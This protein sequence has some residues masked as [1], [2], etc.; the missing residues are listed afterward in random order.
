VLIDQVRRRARGA[1]AIS[2]AA[3]SRHS[4]RPEPG[5]WRTA[6]SAGTVQL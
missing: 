4:G 1:V 5:H 2:E 3:D 6:A